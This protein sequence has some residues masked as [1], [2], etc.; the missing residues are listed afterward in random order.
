MPRQEKVQEIEPFLKP[1]FSKAAF[2]PSFVGVGPAGAPPNHSFQRLPTIATGY[3]DRTGTG[4]LTAVG[5]NGYAWSSSTF[6]SGNINAGNLNFNASNVNPLNNNNRSYGFPVRCVQ[7]LR[8]F[9]HL[10][11]VGRNGGTGAPARSG[12]GHGLHQRGE[13]DSAIRRPPKE[14]GLR[15]VFRLLT[16]IPGQAALHPSLPESL[17]Q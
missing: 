2:H 14:R 8:P 3:R 6:A 12:A 13:V 10:G 16:R 1:C 15:G 11:S 7:H 5:T 9:L 17:R 4:A